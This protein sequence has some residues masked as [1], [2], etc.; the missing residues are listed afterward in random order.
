MRRY[1]LSFLALL[2]CVAAAAG[3]TFEEANQ[4]YDREQYPEA[5]AAY[6][7]LAAEGASSANL[8]Y[9]L[10]T[11][12]YRLKQPGRAAWYYERALALE[13]GH[14]EARTNL[15]LI[16]RQQSA[17][18][19]PEPVAAPLILPWSINAHTVLTMLAGWAF[20]AAMYGIFV[21]GRRE[22][23]RWWSLA[24]TALV[25]GVYGAMALTVQ[26]Q[27]RALAIVLE[28]NANARVAP[29]ERAESVAPVPPG[30]QV[31]VLTERGAWSY[32]ELPGRA[33]G[34]LPRKA[35]A[36]VAGAEAT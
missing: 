19:W 16:H 18:L 15:E 21:L 28:L 36:A 35:V 29:A 34:W 12:E 27:R 6:E 20:L 13:P 1:L 8:F 33:R 10:G 7:K 24:V 17:R 32:C 2:G 11:T 25:L 30:S 4:L 23:F 26:T 5:K 31:R 22:S 3:V 14:P 9:N